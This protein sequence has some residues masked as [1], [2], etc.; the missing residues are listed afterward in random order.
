[1]TL[2]SWQTLFGINN[3]II[4]EWAKECS[5]AIVCVMQSNCSQSAFNFLFIFKWLGELIIQGWFFLECYLKPK[6]D[7]FFIGLGLMIILQIYNN[8]WLE[9]VVYTE[10]TGT[11]EIEFVAKNWIIFSNFFFSNFFFHLIFYLSCFGFFSNL[12]ARLKLITKKIGLEI[13][14][15]EKFETFF[16]ILV[17]CFFFSCNNIQIWLI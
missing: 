4:K 6:K 14:F 9:I 7:L 8:D 1:M 5:S 12:M 15:F 3:K 10:R 2:V 11:I 16:F 13:F 17:R